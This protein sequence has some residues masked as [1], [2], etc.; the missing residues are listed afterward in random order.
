[1]LQPNKLSVIYYIKVT[2]YAFVNIRSRLLNLKDAKSCEVF[3]KIAVVRA[4][5]ED[6]VETDGINCSGM[7]WG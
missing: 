3:R 2:V 7:D 1:M 4:G 5:D 6:G